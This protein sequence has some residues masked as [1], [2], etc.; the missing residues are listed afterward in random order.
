MQHWAA[1]DMKKV[2]LFLA[3]MVLT[4]PAS[5][6]S[7]IPL[8]S[9]P[10]IPIGGGSSAG[11]AGCN[12]LG[13]TAGYLYNNG[14][15][16][17]S[18]SAT[19]TSNG[20]GGDTESGTLTIGAGAAI[21]S[22]GPGG[23]LGSNAFNS[24][25]YLPLAGGTIAGVVSFPTADI[26]IVGSSTGYTALASANVGAS[27]FTLT[28][29]AV[30]DT[31]AVLG[32]AQTF[33][34]NQ[35]FPAGSSTVPGLGVGIAGTGFSSVSTTGFQVIVNGTSRLDYGITTGSLWTLGGGLTIS[36]GN[37]QLPAGNN[38]S[39]ASR[40]ILTSPSVGTIQL[41]NPDAASPVAQTVQAQ[42]VVAG[43]ANTAGA[44]LTINGSKS[45]GSGGGDVVIQTTASSASSGIQNTLV[46]AATF[47]GGT[48][49]MQLATAPQFHS[50]STGAAT[51]TF[52]N[53]PCTG[54]TT[55]QWIPVAINGQSGTW[56]V[57]ACQ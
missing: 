27:N 52:T 34:A 55:E 47:K 31:L 3:V 5:A 29:P 13:V 19:F 12:P 9:A 2:A 18:T 21:T 1:H 16:G 45:N 8:G 48:Q 23:A 30:T 35:L 50:S 20:A 37:T 41:G 54:L 46:T 39:W 42:S 51:Q 36:S 28:A 38:L 57:P 32:T 10:S 53:S 40:G 25:A 14:S 22:S 56:F 7:S 44:T 15:N 49:Q 6:Q 33:T 11:S 17:C 24:T 26:R 4:S 43:N